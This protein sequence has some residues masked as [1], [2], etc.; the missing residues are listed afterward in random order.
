MKSMVY[1]KT[2]NMQL[3]ILILIYFCHGTDKKNCVPKMPGLA[4]WQ[5]NLIYFTLIPK[6]IGNVRNQ[7]VLFNQ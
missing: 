7:S 3:K 2:E 5:E 1:F 4:C 6:S